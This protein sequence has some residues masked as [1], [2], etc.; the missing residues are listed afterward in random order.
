TDIGTEEHGVIIDDGHLAVIWHLWGTLLGHG[1]T[2]IPKHGQPAGR[3]GTARRAQGWLKNDQTS[4]SNVER[5]ES[6]LDR[7]LALV[8]HN[9]SINQSINHQFI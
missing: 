6:T 7:P 2:I 5:E 1:N 4:T 8:A 9:Q 3:S